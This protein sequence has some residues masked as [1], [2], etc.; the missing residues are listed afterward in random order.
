MYWCRD[1]GLFSFASLLD[2]YNDRYVQFICKFRGDFMF[3]VAEIIFFYYNKID[4]MTIVYDDD[5][6]AQIKRQ[7]FLIM[8]GGCVGGI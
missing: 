8:R 7:L 5:S 2:F 6:S 1:F 3:V 4:P